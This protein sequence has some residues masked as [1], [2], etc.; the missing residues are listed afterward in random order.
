LALREI[1]DLSWWTGDRLPQDRLGLWV[2]LRIGST[3]E[4]EQ[5][6]G[7]AG[8]A[9]R[10]LTAGP[11]A[12]QDLAAF[13]ERPTAETKGSQLGADAGAIADLASLLL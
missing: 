5:A 6:L 2:A 9:F 8:W 1:T 4:T 11:P 12:A 10:R 3:A 13:L 7:Q